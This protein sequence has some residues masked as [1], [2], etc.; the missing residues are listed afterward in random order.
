VKTRDTIFSPD[1]R[2]R[3]T[4]FRKV[5]VTFR[6]D[7]ARW[8]TSNYV[9]FIGLNPSVADEKIN[10]ATIR[11]CINYASEWGFHWMCMTNLFAWR[12]TESKLLTGIPKPI[13]PENDHWLQEVAKDAGLVVAAWGTKGVL[14]GRGEQVK[15]LLRPLCTL[16]C[17]QE[18]A[19]GHPQHPLYLRKGLTPIPL[20][21]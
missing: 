9:Q 14:H 1:R 7:P 6:F 19:D 11:R 8:D 21:P 16:H 17:L 20:H 12:E 15:Q 10:D 4:L 18:T 2:Y 13:G 3:Y 5:P